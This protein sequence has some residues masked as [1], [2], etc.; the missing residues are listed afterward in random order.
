MTVG[1]AAS[2]GAHPLLPVTALLGGAVALVAGAVWLLAEPAALSGHL[3][4]PT[5]VALTHAFTL[6]YVTLVYVGTLQQ[7]PAWR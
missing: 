1:A 7:L 3:G 4:S 2:G 5:A 6:L